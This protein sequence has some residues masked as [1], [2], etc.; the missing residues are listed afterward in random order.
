[1]LL[2]SN[3]TCSTGCQLQLAPN[4]QQQILNRMETYEHLLRK[5]RRRP[6]ACF[7]ST[8][9]C[10]PTRRV[11][12]RRRT[13]SCAP[14]RPATREYLNSDEFRNSFDDQQRDCCAA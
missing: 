4:K 5:S 14:C 8:T 6:A 9:V 13:A 3:S 11:S 10:R 1:M 12:Y 7:S 2:T